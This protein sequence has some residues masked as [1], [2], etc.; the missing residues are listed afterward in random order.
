[1]SDLLSPEERSA[2]QAP[3]AASRPPSREVTQAVFPSASQLDPERTAALGGTLKT[4]LDHVTQD[5]SRQLRLSCMARPPRLEVLDQGLLP[6]PDEEAYWSGI[7][8]CPDS[9]ILLSMPRVF[10]AALCERVFGAPFV[11]R[12]DR[13]LTG[14]EAALMTDLTSGW[15]A[16]L[17]PPASDFP[18]HACPPPPLE[19]AGD[20]DPA[21]GGLR[22]TSELLCG[23]VVGT[24]GLSM[25]ASTA[26]ALTGVT[27]LRGQETGG[28]AGPRGASGCDARGAITPTSIMGRVGDVPVE[29]RAILGNAHFTLDELSSLQVGDVIALERRA[30]DPVDI[31]VHDRL[32]CQARAGVAGQLVAVELIGP[33]REETDRE[34]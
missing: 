21:A 25:S 18:I 19:P 32:F 26:L 29:L 6:H 27:P 8:G 4:W 28:G 2:L 5:L 23:E 3:Y 12:E 10:A 16:A 24:V 34:P 15:L 22:W 13:A 14:S 17:G 20:R 31:V 11:L 7:E 1:M 9:H 33:P 30:Q